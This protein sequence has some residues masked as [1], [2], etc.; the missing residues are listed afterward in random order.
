M[1]EVLAKI[2]TRCNLQQHRDYLSTKGFDRWEALKCLENTQTDYQQLQE[3]PYG[4]FKMLVAT[5]KK[6]ES[7]VEVERVT[8]DKLL[9]PKYKQ[10]LKSLNSIPCPDSMF[11][12]IDRQI[13]RYQELKQKYEENWA[14]HQLYQSKISQFITTNG[15]TAPVT[16]EEVTH[17]LSSMQKLDGSL[18]DLLQNMGDTEWNPVIPIKIDKTIDLTA[19]PDPIKQERQSPEPSSSDQRSTVVQSSE[20][21]QGVHIVH[22]QKLYALCLYACVIYLNCQRLKFKSL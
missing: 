4:H 12:N 17:F 15:M 18:Q 13:A 21:S 19:S 1:S 16:A 2:L 22:S 10:F 7:E 14:V 9:H 3:I 11:T 5:I 20:P 8:E 6:Y